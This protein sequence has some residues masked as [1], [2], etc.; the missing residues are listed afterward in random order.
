MCSQGNRDG[1][2][3]LEKLVFTRKK[4]TCQN[5]LHVVDGGD[6]SFKISQKYQKIAG[7]NQHDVEIEAVKAIAQF[8]KN[9]IAA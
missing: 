7:V 2:C 3:P 8:V 4:M 1:L 9:S 6:H 5:E